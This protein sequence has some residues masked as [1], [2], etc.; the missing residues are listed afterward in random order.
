M[1]PAKEKIQQGAATKATREIG[2]RAIRQSILRRPSKIH[3]IIG[4]PIQSYYLSFGDTPIRLFPEVAAQM[5]LNFVMNFKN[6]YDDNTIV[7]R[8]PRKSMI[9]VS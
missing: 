9:Q 6:G 5:F 4:T 1:Y 3:K 8:V 7:H 2:K